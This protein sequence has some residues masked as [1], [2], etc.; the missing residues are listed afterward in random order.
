M[1]LKEKSRYSLFTTNIDI[2]K[3]GLD[4]EELLDSVNSFRE[5]NPESTLVSNVGGW[6]SKADPMLNKLFAKAMDAQSECIESVLEGYNPVIFNLQNSWVNINKGSDYNM[7][8]KHPASSL[9]CCLYLSVPSGKI[10]F[11]DPRNDVFM[12]RDRFA[13]CPDN[14]LT[15]S[16]TP[17]AGDLIV[18]PSWLNHS[19]EPSNS[20]EE[21]VSIASN[22][23]VR[24][25][26]VQ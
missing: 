19:V 22:Y 9:S 10:T 2:F 23:F 24:M 8:H 6:Q 12:E 3:T 4:T 25:Q 18:F 26:D 15:Y 21:R 16:F 11:E 7:V 5:D 14:Y 17:N 1:K 20:E 13:M